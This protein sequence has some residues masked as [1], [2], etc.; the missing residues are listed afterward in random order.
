M[1]DSIN[2]RSLFST[3][4]GAL[5][6]ATA[7]KLSHAAGPPSEGQADSVPAEQLPAG[8]GTEGTAAVSPAGVL[9]QPPMPIQ[10]RKQLFADPRLVAA[11]RGVRLTMNPPNQTGEENVVRDTWWERKPGSRIGGYSTIM[12]EDGKFRLWYQFGHLYEPWCNHSGAGQSV[13]YVESDDGVHFTKPELGL[14]EFYGSKDNNVVIPG[15]VQG[16][17][18]WLDPNAPPECRYRS[19]GN[20]QGYI[21][22]YGSADGIRWPET[23]R[24]RLPSSITG[25]SKVDGRTNI[26]WDVELGRYVMFTRIVFMAEHQTPKGS[27]LYR[28]HRAVRRLES[29]DLIHWDNET[30]VLTHDDTDLAAHA[31]DLPDQP[32]VDYN[33][34]TVFR[35]PD[36]HGLW[37]MLVTCYWHWYDRTPEG[38]T[39]N[40]GYNLGPNANDIRLLVS[41]D[42]KTFEWL[43]D[44]A[45]FIRLGPEGRFDSR[46]LHEMAYP[47]PMGNELWL[48]YAGRN[49]E[50]G[51]APSDI[52]DPTASEPKDAISRAVMRLDGF[53][54]ADAEYT[55]GELTTQSLVFAGDRLL[56]NVDTSGGGQVKVEI[57]DE[58]GKPIP[59]H[60]LADARPLN[61]NSVAM[62]VRW[63]GGNDVGGLA[64]RPVRLRFV[65]NDCK[66]Y[67]FQFGAPKE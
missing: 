67:A 39:H 56:L 28:L 7:G 31:V 15:Y 24:V 29:D 52:L 55:G 53:V 13:L 40:S 17:H 63:S 38:V 12:R 43:G 32:P 21:P 66:L 54:S 48:Y 9:Q 60:S 19:Q 10:S 22:F 36:E 16:G 33:F 5:A 3:G 57:L 6:V 44:R 61:G 11:S 2:R 26:H 50:H 47:I 25:S 49:S 34:A 46:M 41:T 14:H 35:Y 18:V 62:P 51:P 64:G 8:S 59:G 23:H 30:L 1:T 37:F 45:P 42:G 58:A 4:F 27:G 20:G 65:M